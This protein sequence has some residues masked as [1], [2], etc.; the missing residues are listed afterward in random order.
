MNLRLAVWYN[1]AIHFISRGLEFHHQLKLDSFEFNVDEE[2]SRYVCL[3]H[4]TKQKNYQGGLQNTEALH[5]KRMYA[6]DSKACPVKMLEFLI[7][8]TDP[9]ASH[10]FNKCNKD[11][12]AGN[13]LGF[14]IWYT[15]HPLQQ[16]TFGNFLPDICK[17]AG[18]SKR[19][20]AHCLRATAIQWMND[21]GFEARHIMYFSGH[22]NE[23]SIRSY[24]REL[25]STQKKS[26]SATLSSLAGN[27]D[28]MAEKIPPSSNSENL[29][30]DLVPRTESLVA[31]ASM[32]LIT[33][34]SSNRSGI[35][36]NSH[37]QNCS[38]TFNV[39]NSN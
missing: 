31:N 33:S 15:A 24:N 10:L 8:K 23:S 3:T 29:A 21:A 32:N 20:T 36:T 9:N 17:S 18:C 35:M 27:A 7:S 19:Y 13:S 34:D 16:R 39:Q 37:F 14:S 28:S 12:L 5:D 11:A 1:I 26:A 22:R 6:T 4:E 30:I 25:S 2:G 38:F